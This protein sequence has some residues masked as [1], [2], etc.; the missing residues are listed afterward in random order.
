M[1]SRVRDDARTADPPAALGARDALRPLGA[2]IAKDL[3]LELRTRQTAVGM[4]LFALITMVLFQFTVA[5]RVDDAT[6][7]AGGIIW[8]TLALTA[9]LAVSRAWAAE[10]E[11]RVLD[12]LLV[13]PVSRGALL[14]AKAC[15]IFLYMLALEIVVLPLAVVFF[16]EGAG[17]VD[18]ALAFGAAVLADLGIAALG[19]LVASLA[20]FAR[21]RELLVP[22]LF[23]PALLPVVIA[24][25]GAT[26]AVLGGPREVAEYQGYCLFLGVYAVVFALV[27]Y[28]TYEYVFDD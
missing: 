19:S 9:V 6:P 11:G 13:A 28:A 23:L 1:S 2:L 12:G 8:A 3:R 24:A 22:A 21:G 20:A 27:S 18:L 15:T 14:T 10:R 17:P 26:H 4:A 5:S 16:V 7:F 25:G